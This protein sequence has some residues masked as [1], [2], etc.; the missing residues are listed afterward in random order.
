M[1]ERSTSE[2][3][4]NLPAGAFTRLAKSP[5]EIMVK[6]S[7]GAVW[8]LEKPLFGSVIAENLAWV[9]MLGEEELVDESTARDLLTVLRQY[10]EEGADSFNFQPTRGDLYFNLQG[11]VMDRIGPERGGA[12]YLGRS[13]IDGDATIL[14]LFVRDRLLDLT[15][16][17]NVLSEVCLDKAAEHLETVMPGYTGSQPA[18]PWT[19]G[20]YLLSFVD[21]FQRDVTR[22]QAAY[23]F[24]N[25]STLGEG[26]GAGSDLALNRERVADLLGFDGLIENTREFATA[27]DAFMDVVAACSIVLTHLGQMAHDLH[28]W[29]TQEFGMVELGDD[30]SS[31]SSFMPQKKNPVP[32][33]QIRS[34]SSASVGLMSAMM[35]VIK[36]SSQ[37]FDRVAIKRPLM[38][39]MGNAQNSVD[40]M[41]AAL[42]TIQVNKDL[43]R[44]RALK[45][46]TTISEVATLVQRKGD[47]DWRTA[48][49]VTERAV[50][51]AIDRGVELSDLTGAI[52]DEAGEEVCG[53]TFG[54]SQDDIEAALDPQA[55]IESRLTRGSPNPAEAARM[56]E[57]RRQVVAESAA[58]TEDRVRQIS[59]ARDELNKTTT[60]LTS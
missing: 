37:D 10:D 60:R 32:L 3:L 30:Y 11:D 48:H 41:A 56:L 7:A 33:H 34:T 59:A 18:Q 45:L 35:S 14:R 24:A 54:L 29:H 52:L 21:A 38:T 28:M 8:A 13:R 58:W 25:K 6:F 9:A 15:R 31:S 1:T 47:L 53:Q 51:I 44:Q 43:T 2:D 17:L 19:F 49:F 22:V 36:T 55:F 27:Y 46:G 5:S 4:H 42:G 16:S 23:A 39:A 40:Y 26:T 20:H 12:I 57:D 50:R